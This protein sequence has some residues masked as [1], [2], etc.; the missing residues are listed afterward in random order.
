MDPA[1]RISFDNTSVAFAYK[2]DRELKRSYRIYRLIRW[3]FLARTG[4]AISSFALRIGLPVKGIIRST[5]FRQFCGG[6]T[7]AGTLPVVDKL[8]ANQVLTVMD[9]GV[10]AKDTEHDFDF[11]MQEMKREI[12]FAKS[13]PGIPCISCKVTGMAR[14]GLLEK[15]HAGH[16][17]TADEQTEWERVKTR[18]DEVS[19][20][21]HRHDMG[22]YIDAEESW[23]QAPVDALVTE[24]MEKYN[25]EKVIVYN[26]VQLYLKDR[27]DFLKHSYESARAGGYFYGIKLVRGAYMDKERRRAAKLGLPSPVQDTKAD[28]DAA[29]DAAVEFCIH[30]VDRI[31]VC[32]ASHNEHSNLL[33][34]SLV[35]ERGID[36]KHPH[37]LSCQLYGMSDHITFN[38]AHAGFR[39]AKYVPYGPVKDVIHYLGRRAAENTSV[40]GQMG[41]ELQLLKREMERR[42]RVRG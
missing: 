7:L 19:A 29:F 12:D 40:G 23:I 13:R 9:Y 18:I 6:E 15:L 41:R 2:D 4:S 24:M 32:V 38:L 5:I 30:H 8:L 35:H 25:R 39:A 42:L 34:A 17:L 28:T 1:P 36:P 3:P 22:L 11:T 37:L 10:E 14:F 26:T 27:L 31:S 21:A 33:F 16:G 20:Y